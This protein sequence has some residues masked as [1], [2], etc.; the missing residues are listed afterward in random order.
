MKINLILPTYNNYELTLKCLETIKKYEDPNYEVNI[1]WID[2]N[3]NF[4]DRKN[5]LD[6]LNNFNFKFN[7]IFLSKNLGFIK[8]VNIALKFALKFYP[9][10]KF[11]G[12][13]NNDIEVSKDWI[14]NIIDSFG[15]D[16][17]EKIQCI[18]SLCYDSK[19][20]ELIK[21]DKGL[22]DKFSKLKSCDFSKYVSNFNSLFKKE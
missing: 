10:N 17:E 5:V 19:I 12:L 13:I 6:Y 1:I 18:G 2:N 22:N 15:N 20:N 4:D 3:S 21:F 16:K 9:K 11:V 14:K 8:A 7:K